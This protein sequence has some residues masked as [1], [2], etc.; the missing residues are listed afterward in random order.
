[1][2]TNRA[3]ELRAAVGGLTL[4]P[5]DEGFEEQHSGWNLTVTHAPSVIVVA[6]SAAD[7]AAAVRHAAEAGLPV[8]VQSTGHGVSVPADGAVFIST[9][10]LKDLSVDPGARTARLGAGLIWGEVVAE[11]AKSGLAP[12][13]GSSPDV[14]V[15]GY[16]TGGGL[17]VL[18]R[19]FGFAADHVR[20]LEV[21]T[22]DGQVLTVT[23]DS[24]ADLFWAVRG[25]RSNFGVVTAAEID[26][27]PMDRLYGGGLFFPG[28]QSERVLRTYF[29][30]L[31][32]LPE[33]MCSS[34]ILLRFPD[35]PAV[36][37]HNR[38]RF[39]V[40]LRIAYTGSAEEGERLIAPLRAL[41]PEDD[42]VE[43][44]PYTRVGE[45][46]RD[47]PRPTPAWART[48]VLRSF[49]EDAVDA[50]V[51]V[52]GPGANLPPGG[53][54]VRHLGGALS[55]PA[56]VPSALAR[57]E[58][59]FHLF[60]SMPAPAESADVSRKAE[61][62]VLDQLGAWDT[63]M[64]LP[65]FMFSSDSAPDQVRRGYRPEDYERLARLKAAYDPG[66][67]F[68]INHNIPPVPGA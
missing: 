12:L 17:P 55:R 23:P 68:R 64:M 13:N 6:D 51:A 65:S 61:Q 36:P 45:I 3:E 1:M 46:Y 16:L 14:G 40:H 52:A 18:G 2:K 10:R 33:E 8:A 41:G 54:E 5:G 39:L 57:P 35:H 7:V 63:G 38:G 49:G 29:A 15:M 4:F 42:T 58:G 32:G 47:P 28:E 26:L 44:M 30:W 22:A 25:G 31:D 43:E 50:L 62:S 37:E 34:I 11:T 48:A 27:V 19:T 53:V 60:M 21:V 56:A 9:R 66:N 59:E 24:D 20:S 67:I